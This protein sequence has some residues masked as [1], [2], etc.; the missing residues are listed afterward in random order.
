VSIR[1]PTV[2]PMCRWWA[3]D[4]ALAGPCP[5]CDWEWSSDG[6]DRREDPESGEC[7]RVRM[8]NVIRTLSA[9]SS[10]CVERHYGWGQERPD[11]TYFAGSRSDDDVSRIAIIARVDLRT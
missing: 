10:R 8:P 4:I 9:N 1:H 5:A 2:S 6:C 11:P 7:R 3:R